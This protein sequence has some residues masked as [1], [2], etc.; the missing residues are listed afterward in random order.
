MKRAIFLCL[1]LILTVLICWA[2]KA[3]DLLGNWYTENGKS[4]ITIYKCGAKYCG[5]ITW[6]RN[7]YDENGKKQSDDNNPNQNLRGRPLMGI[8]LLKD[9]VNV[10]D[11]KWEK[12]TIYNPE[13]GKTYSCNIEM[14][15]NGKK[16]KVRGFVGISLFG[17]TQ[18]W[19]R[20]PKE[21]PPMKEKK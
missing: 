19:P 12:G 5:K 16:I 9:F 2:Y 8:N 3:D 13:D 17:K 7:P 15:E 20:G 14:M 10:G 18:V 4:I 1:F 6:L 21:I 11:G